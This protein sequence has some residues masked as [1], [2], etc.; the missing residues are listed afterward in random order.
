MVVGEEAMTRRK[1]DPLRA[2]TDEERAALERLSRSGRAPAA[3][4]ARARVLLAV[5]AGCSYTAAARQVGRRSGDAVAHLVS[6]FHREG[7][8]ALE[9]RHGGGP[10]PTYSL[11]AR[12]RILAEWRRTPDHEQDGTGTWSLSTLQRALRQAPDGLPAVSTYTIWCVLH[13]AGLSWQRDRSWC[14]TGVARRRRK[15]GLAT[16]R[17]PDAAAKKG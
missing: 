9:P 14:E 17:D 2:L 5:A 11:A 16:V 15:R 6:R 1:T 12:D 4:V 8:A 7:V 13:D 3:Q 10:V